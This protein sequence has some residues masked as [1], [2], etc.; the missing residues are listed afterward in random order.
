MTFVLVLL[1]KQSVCFFF[2]QYICNI[3]MVLHEKSQI[4]QRTLAKPTFLHLS[5]ILLLDGF[6][7]DMQICIWWT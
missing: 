2:F 5:A 1:L 4:Y 6:S 3:P 7:F